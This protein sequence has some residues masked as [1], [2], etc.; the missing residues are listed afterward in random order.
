MS[1]TFQFLDASLNRRLITL[2]EKHAIKH[3]V[4]QTGVIH[5]SPADEEKVENDLIGLVRGQVFR[6]WQLVTCPDDWSDRYRAYMKV[7]DIPFQEERSN[8]ETWFLIP[9]KHRP[10]LWKLDEPRA[11][12]RALA[13]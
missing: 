1:I 6:S 2:L 5:F 12:K 8:D 3:R 4:D 13:R 9:R 10:R 11:K 7:H